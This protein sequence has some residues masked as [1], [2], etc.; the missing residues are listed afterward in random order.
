MFR[1]LIIHYLALATLLAPSTCCCTWQ[2][3]GATVVAWTMGQNAGAA[4][5]NCC[6]QL[7]PLGSGAEKDPASSCSSD[8]PETPTPSHHQCP[9]QGQRIVA[10]KANALDALSNS[11]RFVDLVTPFVAANA[12][13]Q[14]LIPRSAFCTVS[15][16]S[17]ASERDIVALCHSLRC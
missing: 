16:C 4:T 5:E 7:S 11:T 12:F 17:M 14:R 10:M 3:V 9:C 15:A 13:V 6:C 1:W 2:Q 8:S